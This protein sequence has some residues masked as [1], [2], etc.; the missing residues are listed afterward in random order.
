MDSR[1]GGLAW[2]Q[3]SIKIA[4]DLANRASSWLA[5]AACSGIQLGQRSH[6]ISPSNKDVKYNST[7]F[8]VASHLGPR[9]SCKWQASRNLA[10]PAIAGRR[11]PT[12]M[13]KSAGVGRS[14]LV[15]FWG[16]MEPAFSRRR[17]MRIFSPIDLGGAG[18]HHL[19]LISDEV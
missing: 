12:L 6:E 3:C 18:A 14:C 15:S 4:P 16:G 5:S 10:R 1:I 7:S 19:E 17:G 9:F 8:A 2:Q 13:A 11:K